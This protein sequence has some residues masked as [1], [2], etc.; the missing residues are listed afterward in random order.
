MKIAT[1]SVAAT[2]LVA[3]TSCD[4]GQ[5][6]G[7]TPVN[8]IRVAEDAKDKLNAARQEMDKKAK[9]A[10]EGIHGEGGKAQP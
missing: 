1:L 5:N 8:V 9:E 6:S 7:A 10:M 3:F 2:V 4:N